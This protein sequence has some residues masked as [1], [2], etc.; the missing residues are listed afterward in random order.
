MKKQKI[1]AIAICAIVLVLSN[2]LLIGGGLIYKIISPTDAN[3]QLLCDI[4]A[5]VIFAVAMLIVLVL[6]GGKDKLRCSDVPFAD[7]W[8]VMFPIL[9]CIVALSFVNCLWMIA[10]NGNMRTT[11]GYALGG[12]FLCVAIGVA[13]ELVFR[14]LILGTL[15]DSFGD[16]NPGM[17]ISLFVSSLLFG[18][19]HIGN[20]RTGASVQSVMIQIAYATLLGIA[21]GAVYLRTK[22]LWIVA[23]LH[24]LQDFFGFFYNIFYGYV[25]YGKMLNQGS[26]RQILYY[27]PAV[28][29]GI[30]LLRKGVK[31]REIGWRNQT[32]KKIALVLSAAFVLAVVGT[33]TYLGTMSSLDRTVMLQRLLR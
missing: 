24:G 5:E 13:E 4:M 1:R 11:W 9:C 23:F 25:D 18:F 8:L 17:W 33:F 31:S 22:S 14:V 16:T 12:I 28:V 3:G 10:E 29:V 20:V 7:K 6:I 27:I 26:A 19:Q 2:L 32:L 21:L 30:I 15:N